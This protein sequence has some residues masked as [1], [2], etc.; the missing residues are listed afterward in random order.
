[1]NVTFYGAVREVTG[2][3]HLVATDKDKIILDCGMFQGRRRETYQKNLVFPFDARMIANIIL[4]HAHI[5]HSGRIPILTKNGFNGRIICTRATSDACK[6]LLS[7]SARIQESDAAYINYKSLRSVLM[8]SKEMG[9]DR[10]LKSQRDKIKKLLKKDGERLN[11][12]VIADLMEKY[13]L[14][15]IR[16]LYTSEDVENTIPQ[17]EGY[18]YG[19]EI[20]TGNEM[21]SVFYDA[22]HI[23]GSGMIIIN[24]REEGRSYTIGY[25]GDIG[26]FGK[27]ILKDPSTRFRE[28]DS[29]LDLLIMESTY[30][31]RL[32]EPVGNL[33]ITLKEVINETIDR[34]GS[35][36]IPS[37]AFGRTQELLYLLHALYDKREVPRIPVYVDSPLAVELTRVYTEH[38]EVYDRKTHEQ[39]LSDGENPFQFEQLRFISSVEESMRLMREKK[40]HIVISG[41][42]M[43]EGGRILHHLRY[44]I[45]N[46]RNTIL[47]VGY[48]AANT[49]G[50]RILELGEAYE[51]GGRN[52][53]APTVKF[54]NK[55]YPL[56]AKV[57]NLGGFSAH[58]DRN[59][60]IRLLKTSNLTI[61][62]I[63][64]VHGEEDQALPFAEALEKEGYR[65]FVPRL[66][67]TIRIRPR[68]TGA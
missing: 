59:E 65:A 63:A 58:A 29:L 36:L 52:G 66:G 60:M 17:F 30:G 33:T 44:K 25:T 37:F 10:R 35:L 15:R 21:T 56:K 43:C 46:P 39:F 16:P 26:R 41:S 64:V 40:P 62:Q 18:P 8:K 49:L 1:M 24:I 31:N 53:E 27:P 61:R 57:V 13:R 14:E 47:L 4:S 22:G 5:D 55:I 12:E 2:S 11:I 34:G 28:Q 38:P 42:G 3:M 19:E 48:M 9:G 23:L 51:E 6:Y 54:L 32:H 50:R 68:S 67:E 45:H 20:I 7:D